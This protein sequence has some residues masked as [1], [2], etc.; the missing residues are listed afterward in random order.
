VPPLTNRERQQRFRERKRAADEA[1]PI[2][3][4]V[5]AA[6]VT[7]LATLEKSRPCDVARRANA[8]VDQ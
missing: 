8:N 1:D 4:F 7:G 3:S 6:I 5:R 2:A